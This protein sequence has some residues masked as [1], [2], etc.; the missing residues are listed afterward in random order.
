M[1]YKIPYSIR[2]TPIEFIK[3]TP[4]EIE[5]HSFDTLNGIV[6]QGG[7]IFCIRYDYAQMRDCA[8]MR[9]SSDIGLKFWHNHFKN[10]ILPTPPRFDNKDNR[11]LY[12]LEKNDIGFDALELTTDDDRIYLHHVSG[13]GLCINSYS[14]IRQGSEQFS[15]VYSFDLSRYIGMF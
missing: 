12:K 6:R 9:I 10:V 4:D 15:V 11:L 2:R 1:I 5:L 3:I 13:M 7:Y 14:G 8:G